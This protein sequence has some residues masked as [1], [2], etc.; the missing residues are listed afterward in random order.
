M[1]TL[2]RAIISSE[3]SSNYITLDQGYVV[4]VGIGYEI[5]LETIHNKGDILQWVHHLSEKNWVTPEILA[6][7][8]EKTCA[9]LGVRV[10]EM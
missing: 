3:K 2:D 6:E 1:D 10:Y 4:F 8:I 7:F 5:W 9:H